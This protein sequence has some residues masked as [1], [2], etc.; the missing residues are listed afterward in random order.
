V[1][2]L[3]YD[4]GRLTTLRRRLDELADEAAGLHFGDVDA[5]EAADAYQRAVRLMTDWRHDLTAISSCAFDS[6][7]RP[8]AL[9][10][11]EFVDVLRPTDTAWTTVTDPRSGLIVSAEDHA[12]HVAEALATGTYRPQDMASALTTAMATPATRDIVLVM[13]GPH[14]FAAVAEELARSVAGGD[15][16][17]DA[18]RVLAL[19]AAGFGAAFRAG[20]IERAAWEE[21]LAGHTDPYATA[22][23]LEHAGLGSDALLHLATATWQRWRA[24]PNTGL[25]NRVGPAT[26]TLPIVIQALTT[27]PVAARRFVESLEEDDL[28]ALLGGMDVPPA[29]ALPMLLASADPYSGP[30]AAM[31][32]SMVKVL[33]FL[34]ER[35]RQQLVPPEVGD[36]LGAYVGPYLEQLLGAPDASGYPYARWA[37]GEDEADLLVAGVARNKASAASL[38]VFLD[39]LVLTRFAEFVAA[40]PVDGVLLDHLGGLAGRTERLVADARHDVAEE[41]TA[42]WNAAWSL[43]GSKVSPVAALFPGPGTVSR[44]VSYGVSYLGEIWR[45]NGWTAAPPDPDVLMAQQQA[46][47]VRREDQREAALMAELYAAGRAAGAIPASTPRPPPATPGEPYNRTRVAWRQAAVDDEDADARDRLWQACEDF[48]AGWARAEISRR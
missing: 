26:Q 44:A 15:A 20:S 14:R 30:P 48:E 4:P 19:L 23:V 21:Q 7:F 25:D 22:L 10:G 12:R 47:I 43:L 45:R 27:D 40:G 17:G 34:D 9:R 38:L 8:V 29:V 35:R 18:R 6:P 2:F 46:D 39:A 42:G 16:N 33:T 1:S 41:Q 28:W 32:R 37:L 24:A 11:I 5:A 36:G 31:E 3:G 13:L